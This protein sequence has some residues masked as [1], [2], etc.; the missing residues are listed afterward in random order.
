MTKTVDLTSVLFIF[1][2]VSITADIPNPHAQLVSIDQDLFEI[3]W[4]TGLVIIY[5]REGGAES[6]AGGGGG[7]DN[8]LLAPW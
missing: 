4:F 5:G 7:V 2:N 1:N 3:M 6:K 8:M